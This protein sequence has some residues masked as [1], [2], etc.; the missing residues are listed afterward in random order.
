M[1]DQR[2]QEVF[3][4]YLLV[5]VTDSQTLGRPNRFL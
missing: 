5:T 1:I 4:V 2:Q 3:G